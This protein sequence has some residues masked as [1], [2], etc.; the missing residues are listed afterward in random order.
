MTKICFTREEWLSKV[1]AKIA[2]TVFEPNGYTVPSN[3]RYSCGFPSKH[4]T[5]L[6]NR[7]I[8]ECWSLDASDDQ[9]F[10]ILISPL[11]GDALQAADVLAHEIVHA[12]VGLKHGH[13]GEFAR[14]ARK[15]GLVGKLTAT[16]AGEGLK[17]ILQQIIDEVGEYPHAKLRALNQR[18]FREGKS[19]V[20]LQCT[21]CAAEGNRYMLRMGAPSLR[22]GAPLCP[23]HQVALEVKI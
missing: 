10:E 21:A 19:M 8:G 6:R 11:L 2:H 17:Q 22:Q 4:A 16:T 18:V 20:K 3:I 7:R 23:V 1:A 5:G 14:C 15:I 9:T 13:K 12:T